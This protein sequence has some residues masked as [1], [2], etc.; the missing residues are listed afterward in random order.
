[1]D[2]F[3]GTS[4]RG[5][6]LCLKRGG[7]EWEKEQDFLRVWEVGLQVRR[8][9]ILPGTQHSLVPDSVPGS[10]YSQLAT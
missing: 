1:M 8:A 5:S 10:P 6:K 4:A 9:M 3:T 2:L 7:F